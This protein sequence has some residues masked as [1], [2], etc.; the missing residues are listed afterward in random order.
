VVGKCGRAKREEG[1]A[2]KKRF[3]AHWISAVGEQSR[4]RRAKKQP[5]VMAGMG[6]K[7]TLAVAR[8]GSA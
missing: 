2:E 4:P 6:R 5:Q 7:R 3:R 1:R 8:R